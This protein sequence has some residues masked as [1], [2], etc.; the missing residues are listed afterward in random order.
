MRDP[1]PASTTRSARQATTSP[2]SPPSR[3]RL[4]VNGHRAWE[5]SDAC[6]LDM[7]GAAHLVVIETPQELVAIK[8]FVMNLPSGTAGNAIWIGGVQPKTA[9][10]PSDGWIG[11]D[12]EPLLYGWGGS[13]P[14]DSPNNGESDHAEQ[15]V[16]MEKALP[17]FL[18]IP[19]GNTFGALCE[20]DGKAI[21]PNAAILVDSYRPPP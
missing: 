5:Q 18:D 14:N 12:G 6:N 20:C 10:S 16:A 8:A 2:R 13:E 11:F 19:G 9:T 1:T 21:D 15:F 17:Y 3:Y 7:P 4:I